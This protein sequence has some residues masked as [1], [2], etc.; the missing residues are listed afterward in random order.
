MP[1]LVYA[2]STVLYS[3]VRFAP[4]CLLALFAA[5]PYGIPSISSFTQALHA[6]CWS[7]SVSSPALRQATIVVLY[8]TLLCR[9]ACTTS[10]TFCCL[11]AFLPRSGYR[12]AP[13]TY[14]YYRAALVAAPSCRPSCAAAPATHARNWVAI[15]LV[16][17]PHKSCRGLQFNSPS[18]LVALKLCL[19]QPAA[20]VENFLVLFLVRRPI[21]YSRN[22]FP[23]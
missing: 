21:V 17:H 5:S 7:S 16:P 20:I 23:S 4:A 10:C 12:S 14:A 22:R 8:F 1:S 11:H 13:T 3:T 18:G 9:V 19:E 2:Y 15:S 6:Y